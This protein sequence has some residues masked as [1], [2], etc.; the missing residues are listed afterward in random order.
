MLTVLTKIERAEIIYG[1]AAL[2]H[3]DRVNRAAE[4]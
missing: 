1:F 3:N 4:R 2:G